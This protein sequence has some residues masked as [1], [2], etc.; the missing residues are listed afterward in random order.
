MFSSNK[1]ATQKLVHLP[2]NPPSRAS[3]HQLPRGEC[4]FIFPE[5]DVHGSRQRCTC[6]SF[7]LNHAVPGALC[8]CGH[9]A[10]HHLPEPTGNYVPLDDHLELLDKFKKLEDSSKKLQEELARER[11]ERDVVCQDIQKVHYSTMAMLRYYV[12]EKMEALRL[13]TDDKLEHVEDK[14][15]DAANDVGELATRISNMDE[16]LIRL[17]ERLDSRRRP[18]MSLTPQIEAE[19]SQQP[20]P[21]VEKTPGDAPIRAEAERVQEWDVRV[22]L[23]PSKTLQFAYSV[24]SVAYRR[25]QTRGFHQDLRLPDRTSQSFVKCVE[26]SFTTIIRLRPWMPLQCLRSSEMSICELRATQINP[27]L[28]DYELLEQY[29]LAHDKAQ[30]GDVMYIALQNEH[31]SWTEIRSLPRIFGSDE[32]CWEVD[33]ALDGVSKDASMDYKMDSET[34][35]TRETTSDYN[36]PPPYSS[37]VYPE[38]AGQSAASPSRLEV[39]ANV[40]SI[41]M[42]APMQVG[43]SMSI[44]EH[45]ATLTHGFSEQSAMGSIESALSDDEHRDKRTKRVFF[46]GHQHQQAQAQQQHQQHHQHHQ[47]PGTPQS[48]PA[49]HPS[50]PTLIQISGRS[51]RKVPAAMV[52]EPLNWGIP[53]GNDNMNLRGLLHR[54]DSKEKRPSTSGGGAP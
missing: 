3:E 13:Q 23:V 12:D 44:S 26:A 4:R 51:K 9:Q 16:A 43:A 36:S 31:L 45:D 25:C 35:V 49:P 29:C 17:E 30:G 1:S 8:G 2:R 32:T 42:Q 46:R 15:Q 21:S 33:E 39:L 6:V 53:V 34:P 18:S 24:D 50:S 5:V 14:A 7:S 37:R 38:N 54:H 41:P 47:Q 22:I 19:V 40:A 10:W 28:W 27:A 48:S 52:K 11:R 20:W